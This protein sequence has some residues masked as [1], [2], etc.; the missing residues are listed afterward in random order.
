MGTDLRPRDDDGEVCRTRE[1]HR[2][3][4]V[5]GCLV[6]ASSQRHN[7][8]LFTTPSQ[9]DHFSTSTNLPLAARVRPR[10]RATARPRP[11]PRPRPARPCLQVAINKP[12]VGHWI[13]TLKH[14]ILAPTFCRHNGA[15]ETF[16]RHTDG[17]HASPRIV[18]AQ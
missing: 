2:A 4:G 18:M 11:R 10:D 14:L 12:L 16:R 13:I 15:L 17:R 7:A 1:G 6:W 9:L 8:T 3:A 5:W